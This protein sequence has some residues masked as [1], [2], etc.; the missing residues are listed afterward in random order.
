MAI[1]LS[2]VLLALIVSACGP[3]HKNVSLDA[4]EAQSIHVLE[5]QMH[6]KGSFEVI[7]DRATAT[8]GPAAM[9]GLIGVAVASAH[10][11]SLDNDKE[12][13]VSKH[14]EGIE[15][16]ATVSTG[17]FE[18]LKQQTR[19][20]VVDAM[21]KD[22][23]A[24]SILELTIKDWGLKVADKR[25]ESL[26]TPF[27]QIECVVRHKSGH[28]KLLNLHETYYGKNSRAFHKYEGDGKL[29]ADELQAVLH[30]AGLQIG[31]R[32]AYTLGGNS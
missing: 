15:H 21:A 20:T 27:V 30:E 5:V 12:N 26:V 24:D 17:L 19:F 16:Q 18:G 31:T 22:N 14:I 7:M 6:S 23:A 28:K 25:H 4:K 9:F 11:Q 1:R 2:V 32:M 13:K 8:A 3:V 10:N 29:L